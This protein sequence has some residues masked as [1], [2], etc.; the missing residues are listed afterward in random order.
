MAANTTTHIASAAHA[1]PAPSA[2]S[3][4]VPVACPSW[5][6]ATPYMPAGNTMLH[7]ALS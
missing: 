3:Q 2:T 1:S 4:C 5:S 6:L 7:S